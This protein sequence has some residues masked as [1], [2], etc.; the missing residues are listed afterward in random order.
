[1]DGYYVQ[2]RS[3]VVGSKLERYAIAFK[4]DNLRGLLPVILATRF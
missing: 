3:C 2:I 1:M 4:G